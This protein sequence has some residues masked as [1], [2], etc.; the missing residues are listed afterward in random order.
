MMRRRT[1]VGQIRLT[2]VRDTPLSVDEVI[3]AVSDP[4]AGGLCVFVGTVRDDD[5]GRQVSRLDY[6]AHPAAEKALVD[7]CSRVAEAVNVT[8]VAAIHRTGRL[9][10]GDIAV[11]T[12][13]SAPHRG[14]AFTACEMLIDDLKTSV[15]IWKHQV[16]ADGT[17][18]WVG[19]A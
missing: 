1:I 19:S 10:I 2:G 9:A 11:V 4:G 6:E 16:F 12:A 5:G 15:P 3:A 18:E 8:A 17:D 7:V 13:V 14:E